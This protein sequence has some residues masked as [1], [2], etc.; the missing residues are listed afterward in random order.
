MS[1]F[2]EAISVSQLLFSALLAGLAASVVGGIIG[3]GACVLA[4]SAMAVLALGWAGC[5]GS[6]SRWSLGEGHG[7]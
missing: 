3:A 2:F 7:P 4:G 5:S 6:N 1:S